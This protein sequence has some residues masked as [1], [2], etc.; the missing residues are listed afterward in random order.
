M[1]PKVPLRCSVRLQ[2]RILQPFSDSFS[3]LD[4]SHSGRIANRLG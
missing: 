1:G 3:T 4:F 2:R